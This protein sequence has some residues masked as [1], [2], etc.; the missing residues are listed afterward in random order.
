VEKVPLR[1]WQ[2]HAVGSNHAMT[3]HAGAPRF[4]K[5]GSSVFRVHLLGQWMY[6]VAD[7]EALRRIMK[8]DGVGYMIPGGG[9]PRL[10]EHAEQ[11]Y[12]RKEHVHWVRT[13]RRPTLPVVLQLPQSDLLCSFLSPVWDWVVHY[14]PWGHQRRCTRV[15]YRVRADRLIE[16]LAHR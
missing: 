1:L 13:H 10:I 3:L 8:G 9:F 16:L 7:P 11:M 14:I 6:V 4:K 15:L 5:Y 12:D 2:L